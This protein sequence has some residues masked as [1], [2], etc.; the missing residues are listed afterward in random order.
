MGRVAGVDY[1][2][3]RNETALTVF[4]DDHL[5]YARTWGRESWEKILYELEQDLRR[6]QVQ[7]LWFDAG[8]IG[9]AYRNRF[10][11]LDT[12]PV[13][14]SSSSGSLPDGSISMTHSD[15]FLPLLEDIANHEFTIASQYRDILAP[16]LGNL[17]VSLTKVRRNVRIKATKGQDDAAFSLALANQARRSGRETRQG[18]LRHH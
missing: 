4:D 13:V 1:G 10:N 7:T 17:R 15:L 18:A 9:D 11:F 12:V 5:T 2:R 8:G 6:L 16:Q 3:R 14:F